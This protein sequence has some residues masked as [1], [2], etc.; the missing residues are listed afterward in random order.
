MIIVDEVEFRFVLLLVFSNFFV[1]S[2][3]STLGFVALFL[4]SFC[5]DCESCK[6]AKMWGLKIKCKSQIALRLFH[7]EVTRTSVRDGQEQVEAEGV[8]IISAS[9]RERSLTLTIF[10]FAENHLD[11]LRAPPLIRLEPTY[12]E[13]AFRTMRTSNRRFPL[14][15]VA[16]PILAT[17]RRRRKRI[18]LHPSDKL[19]EAFSM[20]RNHFQ[21]KSQR[22]LLKCSNNPSSKSCLQCA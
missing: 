9:Y 12:T 2:L 1:D 17:S 16:H 13:R 10:D 19:V 7:F 8:S 5:C 15:T 4:I 18:P 21:R 3:H 6:R 14:N 11:Q 20:R 22:Q